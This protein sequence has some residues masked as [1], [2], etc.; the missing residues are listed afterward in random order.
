MP[1][2]RFLPNRWSGNQWPC[3]DAEPFD[4]SLFLRLLAHLAATYRF[5]PPPLTDLLDGYAADF[6]LAGADATLHYDNWSLSLACRSEAV[7]DQV[8][9]DLTAL[10]PAYFSVETPSPGVH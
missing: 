5:P 7:R 1:A 3:I 10:P 9:A 6:K 2:I 8:L 4:G